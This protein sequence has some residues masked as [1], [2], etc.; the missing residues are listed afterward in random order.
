MKMMKFS[1]IRIDGGTQMRSELDQG[2][3]KEYADKMREG[4]VFDPILTVYDGTTHWLVDGFHRYFAA[5]ECGFKDISVTYKPGSL[6]DAQDL[7]LGANGKHGLSRTNADKRKAVETALSRERHANKSDREI[8]KLCDVSHPMVAAIRNPDA[9]DK[10]EK[11]RKKSE[12]NQGDGSN[13]TSTQDNESGK[14]FQHDANLTDAP[15]SLT[16]DYGPSEDELRANEMTIR[17]NEKII[18]DMLESDDKLGFAYKE[19]E[20]LNAL[21]AQKEI[22]IGALMTEKNE[23]IKDA[24]R[25]Q[26]QLDK[27]YKAKK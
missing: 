8:A 10:Q 17:A 12:K 24:K 3:V 6:E 1:E 16:Q 22:R 7:S 23:A 21:I 25:A 19:I 9:K 2:R 20:R 11:N 15:P 5:Q 13:S 26:A 14:G 4:E 27:I 18:T